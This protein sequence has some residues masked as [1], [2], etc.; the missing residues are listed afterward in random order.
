MTAAVQLQ[1]QIADDA[2][3][4][5]ADLYGFIMWAYPWKEKGTPLE[6]FEGPETWVRSLADEISNHVAKHRFNGRDPVEPIYVAVASGNGAAKSSFAGML[7]N[8]IMS[9]RPE[10]RVT[11]TANTGAQLR[12]KTWPQIDR[13]NRLSITTD[14][15][16]IGQEYV[17]H[18][19][20]PNNWFTM[21][22]TWNTANTQASAGQHSRR[23]SSVFII[24]EASHVPEVILDQMDGGLTDGEP[25]MILLG[26]CTTRL[27]RLFRAV[28]GNLKKFYINRSIDTRTCKYTNK[29]LIAQWAEQRGENSDWFK[30][31]VKGEAPSADDLQFID[32]LRVQ[33][34]RKRPTPEQDLNEPLILGID[35]A[36]GGKNSNV[37]AWRR[38]RDMRSIPRRRIPGEQTRDTTLMVTLVM[39]E[40][41]EKEPDAVFGDAGGL[42]GPI[43]DRIRQLVGG[44][45][46]VVDVYFGGQAP[47]VRRGDKDVQRHGNMRSY[48]WDEYRQW[49]VGG[50]IEDEATLEEQACGPYSYEDRSER[51]FL[52]SKED[53]EERGLESPDDTDAMVCTFAQK[54]QVKADREARQKARVLP[55][56]P[57]VANG[58]GWMR[59]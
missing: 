29:V 47:T 1:T 52:E 11:V 15:F 34:A 25:F 8:W 50:C 18:K 19:E 6:D 2:A 40:I 56:R 27:S 13:W 45:I 51:M 41:D 31:H 37:L 3:Q 5:Y 16:E 24:D 36:R 49:L 7:D 10:S 46:P 35:F 59:H 55:P 58:K 30:A 54:V 48:M 22:H 43:M 14:W 33:D 4:Y 26:N 28:F 21:A 23:G 42:G 39:N 12:T 44:R 38:G 32:S 20:D 53:M 9:T 17:R 57:R